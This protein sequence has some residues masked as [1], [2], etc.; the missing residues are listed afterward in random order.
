MTLYKSLF[1]IYCAAVSRDR[2]VLGILIYYCKLRFLRSVRPRL[3][4]ARYDLEQALS[5]I[6]HKG[7][8]CDN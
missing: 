2:T 5:R 8:C 1:N 4:A 7:M 6:H 3:T